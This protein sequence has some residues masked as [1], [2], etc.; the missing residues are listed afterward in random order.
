MQHFDGDGFTFDVIEWWDSSG[1]YHHT[2]RQ[3]NNQGRFVR[4]EPF[5]DA[6]MHDAFQITGR[7]TFPDGT[8][9][10]TSMFSGDTPEGA[11]GWTEGE[12][13]AD[14]EES[15]EGSP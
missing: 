7:Y 14:I 9:R 11:L 6:A 3:R 15:A 8:E 5:T 2:Q 1:A 12:L 13:E 4:G 10:Y